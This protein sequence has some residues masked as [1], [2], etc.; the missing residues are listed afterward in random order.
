MTNGQAF[1][2]AYRSLD[3]AKIYADDGALHGAYRCAQEAAAYFLSLATE[4][5]RA[6]RALIA[7]TAPVRVK[8][9]RATAKGK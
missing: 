2:S 6:M 9:K 4:K 7:K 3:L 1:K 8:K 5:D